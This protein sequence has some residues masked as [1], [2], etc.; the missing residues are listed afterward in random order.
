[1]VRALDVAFVLWCVAWI[2]L[3][4]VIAREVRGLGTVSRT[5][6]TAGAA[7]EEA[8]GALAS[9]E[10]APFVGDDVVRVGERTQEAGKS[11]RRS[12]RA[13][14]E[15]V[16]NLSVLLAL[17]IGLVPTLP[18]LVL[19]V[20]VRVARAREVRRIRSILQTEGATPELKE[21]LAG[22][23]VSAMPYRKLLDVTSAPCRDLKEGRHDDLAR[24]ELNRLGIGASARDAPAK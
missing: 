16:D 7:L 17:S 5:I 14:R 12:G 1:M 6:V 13:S 20:P 2:V 18:L 4:L 21:L 9:L 23:A 8:G 3:A 19:Y 11:A 24:V 22:R 15:S 10:D